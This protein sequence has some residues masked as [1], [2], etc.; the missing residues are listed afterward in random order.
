V[1]I[2][3]PDKPSFK[4]A[5]PD[6]VNRPAN[7]IRDLGDHRLLVGR[8]LDLCVIDLEKYYAGKTDYYTILGRSLGYNGND[9]QD[10]GIVKDAKG[11]WWLL[12]NDKLIKFD[13][14]KITVDEKPAIQ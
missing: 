1:F 3:D 2:C 13:P 8:M 11:N 14:E 7:V 4:A 6:E 9:C 10:N 12:T 5:L